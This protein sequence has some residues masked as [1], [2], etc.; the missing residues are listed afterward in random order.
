MG[1]PESPNY[2]IFIRRAE[3]CVV[4]RAVSMTLSCLDQTDINTNHAQNKSGEG[5]GFVRYYQW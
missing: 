4:K 1:V 3:P 5:C 2:G